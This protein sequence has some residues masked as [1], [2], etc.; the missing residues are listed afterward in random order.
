MELGAAAAAEAIVPAA[1]AR[2]RSLLSRPLMDLGQYDQARVELE[3]A[4]ACAEV[5]AHTALYA[6]VHE[7]FGRYWTA[8]TRTA[9][10]RHTG[11]PSNS[12]SRPRSGAV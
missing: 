3:K 11:A 8:S 12:T 5:S 9:P 1:E 2:L 4:A 7:F 6:S 10:S